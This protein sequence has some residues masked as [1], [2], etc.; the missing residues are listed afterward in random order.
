MEKL[1]DNALYAKMA[2]EA[3]KQGKKLAKLQKEVEYEIEVLEWNKKTIE[4]QKYDPETGEPVYDEAGNPIMEEILVDDYDSPIM[5]EE[6][7]IDPETGEKKTILVQKHHTEKR[8]KT[9]EY[10]EM[11][12]P[13][14]GF[15]K[16]EKSKEALNKANH[17]IANVALYEFE[18]GK[19]I[20]A[21]TEN[22]A[23]LTSFL[24]GLQQGIYKEIV[25][26]TKEDEEVLL[27]LEQVIAILQ[28]IAQVQSE[29]WV[30]KYKGFINEINNAETADEIRAIVIDYTID[31]IK[32]D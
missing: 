3:T 18:E 28:G 30:L 23:K 19:H 5:V 22:V 11:I 1:Y 31:F 17:Y 25:W 10:L 14:L 20:E 7:I 32:E 26:V 29:I 27:N 4:V 6:E 2:T 24:P 15:L 16:A 12:D 8:T 21:S 13:D 9:V